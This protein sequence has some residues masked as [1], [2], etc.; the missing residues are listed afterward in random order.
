VEKRFY[1]ITQKVI[2]RG[3]FRNTKQLR[4]KIDKFVKQ[5]N[6]NSKPF[7]WTA[8][9]DSILDKFNRLLTS[10]SGTT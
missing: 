10:L 3:P 6:S 9:A 1:I 5:Y 4:E 7:V 8:T 2:R